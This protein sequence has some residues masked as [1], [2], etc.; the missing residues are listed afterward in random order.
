MP[1][2]EEGMVKLQ[3]RNSFISIVQKLFDALAVTTLIANIAE[4]NHWDKTQAIAD[5]FVKYERLRRPL[6]A[7]VQQ[8]TLTRF[9]HSPDKQW[10]EYSQKV[11]CRNFDQVI[12]ALL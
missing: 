1:G 9:P 7:Y 6:M 11:Y 8:T 3:I 5:A 12:E 10:Q 2:K 4:N